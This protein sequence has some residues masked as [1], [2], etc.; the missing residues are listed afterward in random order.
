Y[1][2]GGSTTQ[3]R[4]VIVDSKGSTVYDRLFPI[5]GP[6]TLLNID[7]RSGSRGIYFVLVGDASGKRLVTGKVHVR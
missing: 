1:N 5:T 7:L 6:Y 4:I 3:R 2:N